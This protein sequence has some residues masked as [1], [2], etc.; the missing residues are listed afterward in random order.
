MA[1][2]LKLKL[3]VGDKFRD[4]GVKVAG[5]TGAGKDAVEF[6]DGCGSGLKRTEHGLQTTGEI[7]Q[8][9]KNFCGFVF[10]KLN[11]LIVGFDGFEGLDENGLACGAGAVDN[12]LYG[13]A[14]FGTDGDDEAVVALRDVIFSAFCLA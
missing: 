9:A 13:A 1:R 12:A 10:G 14:M 11:E 2:S 8:D 7:F 3:G 4:A 5:K 6:G